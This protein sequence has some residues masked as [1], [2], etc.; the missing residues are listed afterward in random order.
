MTGHLRWGNI[1]LAKGISILYTSDTSLTDCG[2][3]FRVLK[4]SMVKKI[5]PLLTVGGS[6]FL[7]E[8]LVVVLRSHYTLIEIPIYYRKR[9][10]TSK[11][12]GSLRKSVAVGMN[13]LKVVVMNKIS[14]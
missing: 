2:C 7:S 14:L 13:M 1:I 4:K 3:T 9:V 10:G 12:T 11:I 5:L 8:L 6:Y